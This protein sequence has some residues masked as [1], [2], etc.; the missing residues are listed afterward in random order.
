MADA[1]EDACCIGMSAR[2]RRSMRLG[3]LYCDGDLIFYAYLPSYLL[4]IGRS[5]STGDVGKGLFIQIFGAYL[6]SVAIEYIYYWYEFPNSCSTGW[7]GE[8]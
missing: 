8:R 6:I 3:D 1:E 4:M 2:C 5:R 7:R